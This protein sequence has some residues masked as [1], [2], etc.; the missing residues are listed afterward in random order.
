MHVIWISMSG[1]DAVRQFYLDGKQLPPY[2]WFGPS[3]PATVWPFLDSTSFRTVRVASTTFEIPPDR[4]YSFS[5]RALQML[6]SS[7]RYHDGYVCPNIS[8]Y[9][10]FL[11]FGS[12]HG[13]NMSQLEDYQCRRKLQDYL[14]SRTVRPTRWLL[15]VPMLHPN[16]VPYN[17]FY[18][19]DIC[20][21]ILPLLLI[22]VQSDYS[23]SNLLIYC[24]HPYQEMLEGTIHYYYRC[25]RCC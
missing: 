13:R 14:A 2:D 17:K 3:I 1:N 24:Y 11:K 20:S 21:V 5:V 8:F 4:T 12:H 7:E 25:F 18:N 22:S 9:L 23:S 6:G 16:Y 10:V 15:I 19:L